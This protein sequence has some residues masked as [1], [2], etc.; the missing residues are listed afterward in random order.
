MEIKK[1]IL[2]IA[3]ILI[4][5]AGLVLV[6]FSA[7]KVSPCDIKISKIDSGSIGKLVSTSGKISYV[8]IH[9]NGH[10]FL[11]L[12]DG[13][14]RIEVPIFSSLASKLNDG[15]TK[16]DLRKGKVVKITGIVGEY[17]GQLQIVP[18]KPTDIRILDSLK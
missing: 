10:I 16:Y 1:N 3:C 15:M 8:R 13:D 7:L 18:Q 5:S 17:K 4:S 12:T 9:P 14:S 11:T 6:Y 2:I